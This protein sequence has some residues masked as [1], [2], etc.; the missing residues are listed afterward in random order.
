MRYAAWLVSL[1]QPTSACI[2]CLAKTPGEC[3]PDSQT[4][5]CTHWRFISTPCS[6]HA[7][8]TLSMNWR[9]PDRRSLTARLRHVSYAAAIHEQQTHS[10]RRIYPPKETPATLDILQLS[11]ET[12]AGLALERGRDRLLQ[13]A[14]TKGVWYRGHYLHDGAVA[15]PGGDVRPG[16][17]ER[18]PRTGRMDPARST[19]SCDSRV[20]SSVWILPNDERKALIAFLK[21]L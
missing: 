17:P 8:R 1:K 10:R 15:S 13:G 16:P 3:R 20:T 18:K 14:V 5:R 4:K 12:D 19:D 7:T 2:I 9:R 21:S 11:V 6:R